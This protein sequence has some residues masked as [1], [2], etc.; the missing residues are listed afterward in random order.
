MA[1]VN[2]VVGRSGKKFYYHNDHLGS[3][4]AV[5]D[6]YGNK[7]VERDFTPFGERINTDVYD[8]EPR[9]IEEDES[10]FTG[11]DWDE[12]VGLYY[13]N[14]RWYDP[15]VGRFISEDSVADDPNLYGY[16]GGNPVNN[17]DPTGHFSVGLQSGWGLVGASLNA[18]ALISGDENIGK[19]ASAFSLFMAVKYYKARKAEK[20]ADAAKENEP[21]AGPVTK[22]EE[23]PA[24]T[25]GSGASSEGTQPPSE[26]TTRKIT[27]D[28]LAE[29]DAI[30]AK[31]DRE[32]A[33][34]FEYY[35]TGQSMIDNWIVSET[36]PSVIRTIT[37]SEFLENHRFWSAEEYDLYFS[38]FDPVTNWE[39]RYINQNHMK[40]VNVKVWVMKNGKRVTSTAT[41]R[42]HEKLVKEV[43]LIFQEIYKAKYPIMEVGSWVPER[44]QD[45]YSTGEVRFPNHPN[46]MAID[47]N[48]SWNPYL[49]SGQTN[50]NYSPGKNAYSLS[51]KSK[52]VK[53]FK[54]YGW[55]WG[56][57]WITVK[58]YMHFSKTGG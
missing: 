29:A 32:A 56:G 9:D 55:S 21:I 28:A 16:C 12:D 35:K 43:Q 1:R 30:M 3:A 40:S 13:Y 37:R 15:G 26:D 58:D 18:V 4:L 53:I 8:D 39:E 51:S 27:E 42:I 20:I 44:P 11:K 24:D 38:D 22:P 45:Y 57:D 7:V 48:W 54:K 25:S 50:S 47:I 17:I 46:G 36:S 33:E 6:Q 5:T 34:L 23:V 19:M 52:V 49:T 10:G 41:F 31:W 14:A 2:G